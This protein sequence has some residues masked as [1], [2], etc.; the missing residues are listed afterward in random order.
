MR[1]NEIINY[2]LI[3]GIV[4]FAIEWYHDAGI[5]IRLEKREIE[6]IGTLYGMT[7]SEVLDK[8]I[9]ELEMAPC[10][11]YGDTLTG[12]WEETPD[13]YILHAKPDDEDEEED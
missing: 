2:N 10:N 3:K 6:A 11:E 5:A 12:R 13:G 4:D 7:P 8:I 1:K 9:R